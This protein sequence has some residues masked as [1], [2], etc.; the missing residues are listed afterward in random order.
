MTGRTWFRSATACWHAVGDET[1]VVLVLRADFF[2]LLAEHSALA[3]R[4][5]PAT[6]LVGPPDERELRRI[7]TEPATRVGLR[8]EPALV[9]LVV[10]EV[11]DRP[12]VLPVLST[13]LVRTWEHRDGD[14]LSVASYRVGG[15]VGAA[16]QRVGEEAWAAFDDD[17]QRAACR[18]LLL[19]LALNENGS[20]VRRW[21]RRTDLVRPDDPAA[22]AALAVLTD[23]RLVVARADDVGIA[24]EA[25]LTG[26]PR[27]HGWLEDGRS[28]ADVRERLAGRRHRVGGS[29]S[30]SGRAVPRHPAA[31]R[32]RPRRGHPGRPHPAGAR[33]PHRV[34]RRSGPAAR[35]TAGTGR[36]GGSRPSP[37][38]PD[39][40][41][42]CRDPGVRR[43]CRRLRVDSAAEGRA[44]GRHGRRGT[45]GGARPSRRRLRPLP[46][47]RRPGG[48]ARPVA[49]DRER[50]VR[51]PAARGCRDLHPARRRTPSRPPPSHPTGGRCS[52]SPRP[53]TSSDGRLRAG[54][55]K[56][57]FQLGDCHECGAGRSGPGRQRSSSASR[58]SK[59]TTA[60]RW[61]TPATAGCS[62]RCLTTSYALVPL[63]GRTGCGHGRAGH[64]RRIHR[65]D[66]LI[67]RCTGRHTRR[68]PASLPRR[69]VTR[70]DCRMVASDLAVLRSR[71]ARARQGLAHGV[72][73]HDMVLRARCTGHRRLHRHCRI[74]GLL[75]NGR[76]DD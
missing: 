30:G 42:A 58:W 4:A 13:A 47:V 34:S 66:V 5:G 49:R 33:L 62:K 63:A 7:M 20:W 74:L 38:P 45:A 26:W 60:C 41:R 6:V 37:G 64:D 40:R 51:H 44:G 22:A 14:T 19:R 31:G 36:P 18:R 25:L 9:D 16:L 2:G 8:V 32:A 35:R 43:L 70:P 21:A 11:R 29:R 23:R 50:P 65:T 48:Q 72:A 46:A 1:R 15:G 27:L 53:V 52:A 71:A 3:R 68:V 61:S 67:W 24:H 12:G 10:A 39:R 69:T 57:L 17:A 28:R 55:R 56:R 73:R 54:Q 59:A 75:T 76:H